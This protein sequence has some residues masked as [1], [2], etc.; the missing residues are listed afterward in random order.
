[1]GILHAETRLC[2]DEM[3]GP[4]AALAAAL[5]YV[6]SRTDSRTASRLGLIDPLEAVD[7]IPVLPTLSRH[8]RKGNRHVDLIAPT[9]FSFFASRDG[10]WCY[11]VC[12]SQTFRLSSVYC[13]LLL[14]LMFHNRGNDM[15]SSSLSTNI[16]PAQG[17]ETGGLMRTFD[18]SGS[19]LGPPELWPHSLRSVVGLILGSKFP[20]FLAWGPELGLLYN[21]AYAAILGAKHPMALGARFHDVWPEVWDDIHPILVKALEGESS[22]YENLPLTLLRNGQEEKAWFTFSYSPVRNESEVVAGM[23]CVVTETTEQVLVEQHR[24]AEYERMR[25]LF[26]QAPGIIAVLREPNHIFEIANDAFCQLVGHRNL[27]GKPVREGLPDLAGQGFYELLDEVHATGKPYFGREASVKLQRRPDGPLEERFVDFVYQPTFDHRG[28]ITGIFIEGNDVTEGVLAHQALK[29]ANRRKDEFLAMLAHELRNPLAPIATA[30]ELLKL[31]AFDEARVRNTSDV[32]AR[33]VAHLTGLVDDLLDVS[34]VTR[35]LITL[36]EETLN[37]S[38]VLADAIEQTHTLMEARRHHFTVRVPEGQFLVKGDRTRLTQVFANLLANAAKYTQPEGQIT[39]RV[40]GDE[41]HIEV[42]VEDNGAGI[43]PSL[44]TNI[45]E[46]FTQGERTPDRAQGGLGLGLALVKSLVELHNGQVTVRSEGAGKGSAFTVTLTREIAAKRHREPR[47]SE[48][49]IALTANRA[50]VLVVDDN[51]DA[52]DMLSLSLQALGHL[53]SV[54]YDSDAA[55]AV[56]ERTSPAVL[57]LDIGL[58]GMNGYQLAR[59]LRAAPETAGSLLVAV[60]GYGQPG[61]KERAKHAG[62]DHHLVKPVNFSEVVKLLE[63]VV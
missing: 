38:T 34:R 4:P 26:Q 47:R 49:E 31:S 53:V 9:Q 58:P 40:Q 43:E 52:A 32:I 46:L 8:W 16:F 35:G 57:F 20:M 17:G 56:A 59:R 50:K 10:S 54:A 39:L 45:F 42:T 48:T 5:S 44:Q 27:L 30:A 24:Q 15:L 37:V 18:W 25:G 19:S 61:D 41:G 62:F 12:S 33:Q 13:L 3:Q 51:K 2:G 29:S 55:L 60:T 11:T 22:Y 21:D 36:D 7:N 23:F 1:V 14:L 63:K 6:R 28:N